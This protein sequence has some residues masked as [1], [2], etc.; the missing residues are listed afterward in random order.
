MKQIK[1]GTTGLTQKE[2]IFR[3]FKKVMG[4]QFVEGRDVRPTLCVKSNVYGRANWDA[5]HLNRIMH[6]IYLGL[7]DGS[8][9]SKLNDETSETKN[10][11]KYTVEKLRR[12]YA[13][14][15]THY[16]MKHDKRLNG[17]QIATRMANEKKKQIVLLDRVKTDPMMNA[18]R[19]L[20]KSLTTTEDRHEVQQ[21]ISS[22]IFEI[23]L[24]TFSI[25]PKVIPQVVLDE[26]G[27]LRA[28]QDNLVKK[29]AA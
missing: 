25:S 8:I 23:I 21:Y 2:A 22:R 7:E 19:E 11:S 14:R 29:D 6:E 24:E 9:P 10:R 13:N 20:L 26:M 3:I 16:W 27:L 5:S 18:L 4:P 1:R 28:S 17:G 12:E 15:I